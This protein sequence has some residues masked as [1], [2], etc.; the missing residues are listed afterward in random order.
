MFWLTKNKR[1]RN[2]WGMLQRLLNLLCG[3]EAVR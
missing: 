2:R 3:C 1:L